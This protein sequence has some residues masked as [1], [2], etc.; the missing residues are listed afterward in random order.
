MHFKRLRLSGFK[1]FVE[2]TELHIEPGLTGV[3]GPNGC[4]KSNLLEAL[5]WVMGESS[6]KRMRASGMDD[7]IFS[8]SATRPERNMAEVT[9]ELDNA[10]RR[11]PAAFN[12]A[13]TLEISRRIEREAGSA[14][15][16]NG[17]DARAKDV[18]LLFADAST[19]S[20]S[21]A[22]VRQGQIGEIINAKPQARRRILEE[23]AGITGLYTRRHEAELRLNAAETN[24]TRL[25]DVVGQLEVQLGNLKRQ[26]RQATRYKNISGDIRK[27]EATQLYVQWHGASHALSDAE[28]GLRESQRALA[29]HTRLAA[30]A[31]KL[32]T[33]A[34]EKVPPLREKETIKAAVLQR[35]T[36]EREGQEAEERRAEERKAELEGRLAQVAQDLER[37]RE[38]TS[39]TRGVLER[40]EREETELSTANASEEDARTAAEIEVRE[41]GEVLQKVEQKADE[42]AASLSAQQ[43]RRTS[44][45]R[46]VADLSSRTDR[47][48][49]ELAS[50]D[51]ALAKLLAERGPSSAMEAAAQA[52]NA[53]QTAL[54]TAEQAVESA[55]GDHKAKRETEASARQA[56]DQARREA[57]RLATEVATL[58]KVLSVQDGQLWPPLIDALTVT[59][60]Y[61]AALGAA[62]GDDL[63]VPTD[64]AAPIHWRTLAPLAD[65]PALPEGAR[66]L[67]QVVDAPEALARRLTQ[68]G[69][70]EPGQGDALQTRLK[71]GQ[72]LV[73]QA[74]DLWRWDGYAAAADAPTAAA[75]RLAERN[76]LIGLRADAEAASGL[77][78]TAQQAFEN[79]QAETRQ[80]EE[81]L[82]QAR[83]DLRTA[84]HALSEARNAQAAQERADSEANA[85]KA[86]LEE[87][88]RRLTDDIV[89]LR[90]TLGQSEAD[91]ADLPEAD[92]L[93]SELDT[94]RRAVGEARS[95]YT[96]TKS[97]FDSFERDAQARTQRLAAIASERTAWKERSE[98]AGTQIEALETRAEETRTALSELADLPRHW[99]ERREK[100]FRALSQAENE[101]KAA[102]DALA[103]AETHL[104]KCNAQSREA[105]TT[106]SGTREAHARIEERVS[107]CR[108]RLDDVVKRI[109]DRL[110]CEPIEAREMAGLK[111][112]QDLPD[113][114]A[115]DKRLTRLRTE[116]ERLGG[117]NLRADEEALEVGEQ[118]DTLVTEREDLI[119]AIHRLRQGIASLNKEGRERLVEAFDQV[120]EHFT[121]LFTT[122]FGGGKASL[123]FVESDDPLEA[124]LE[125]NARPPGKRTQVL[126]LL[127]GGEQALTALALIFAVFMTNPSPI[128][129]LDECDAPLDDANVER[130][131]N[132]LS[133]MLKKTDTRF[134]IIT[135]HP[136]TMSRM[137]RLFGVTMAERGVSQLVSVDL[138][139]AEAYREAS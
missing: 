117:V 49:A 82:A 15:R 135:H 40:L 58:T 53:A 109:S 123:E 130:F 55:D 48:S 61:E 50:T 127:S 115:I 136:Y 79:A 80:C 21:P 42:T 76:R 5:R 38:I 41:S 94:A 62:L 133:E 34:A 17:K 30:E 108:E 44:L 60:G 106:L 1:S 20:R 113:E 3:V 102:A 116:R 65:A 126:S 9:I 29:E 22:L 11:A 19:G 86:V 18:Q 129:V 139:T 43:A 47:L 118:L 10:D 110:E 90:E 32:Q 24:L 87:T 83:V 131:C 120:N 137:N 25:E 72:R 73:S 71:S 97:R 6:Y 95:H 70:V 36:V 112:D 114:E 54:D 138:E 27:A 119:K 100:L 2:P 52:A 35:L 4:G 111:E 103:M 59:E 57:E 12:D 39:D 122:L 46:A 77:A 92:T 85:Q 16:I 124:G 14:Y 96:E 89:Q 88:H 31:S 13:D 107:G 23:A 51:E 98:R 63:D 104:N 134:L 69:I 74:G 91:L 99:E 81:A 8:G 101:R 125:I 7:V 93:Q 56:Y 33:E 68:V 45:E 84:G 75:Q 26:A 64:E 28:Q 121:E 132:L 67:S 37:E 78:A 66:P 105:E 128:C